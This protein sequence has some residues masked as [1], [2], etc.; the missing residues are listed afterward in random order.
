[1][2]RLRVAALLLLAPALL[3][4]QRAPSSHEATLDAFI[5]KGMQDWKIP[6][7]SVAVVKGDSV[8]YLKGFGVR[9]LGG[10]ERV[11]TGTLFGMM[12]T[13]K[14]MTALALAM[15]VDSGKVAWNDP[16]TKHLPWFQ[17]SDPHVTRELRVRD[18]LTHNAGL[19][20]A[21]LLWDRGDFSTREVL[22]R[23]RGLPMAYSLRSSFIYNNVMYQAAGEVVAA[24]S[25]MPWAEFVATRIMAPIGMSRS[26][27]T[28]SA[29]RSSGDANVSAAHWEFDD[30]IRAIDEQPVDVVPAAGAAWSSA[31]D[32]AKWVRFWLDSGRVNGKRLVS[33]A[34]FRE[35]LRPH[36]FVPASEFYPTAQVTRPHWVTYGLGWFEQDYRG[37]FVAM[38][39][40]SI[41]GRTAIFGLM[42]D[43]RLG[44]YVFGNLDHAEF[45]HALM[46]RVF[47]LYT[48]APARDWSAEF[49]TLYGDLKARA[50]AAVKEREG[51]R[52]ANTSPSVPLAQYAA[53]YRH[54]VWGDVQVTLMDGALSM[55]I[56]RLPANRGRL[57]HWHHDTFRG[58]L[59]DGRGGWT[60]VTF[61][62]G[63]SGTV[64]ALRVEDSS[65]LEFTRVE[66]PAPSSNSAFASPIEFQS[67]EA[68]YGA[69]L[70]WVRTDCARQQAPEASPR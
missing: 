62:L 61:R 28:L 52:V 32:V 2:R 66:A 8:L 6:G 19:G 20:N 65:D 56:G 21:D 67:G 13:T 25:G 57:E 55:A 36:A 10:A 7:L 33:E 15:L 22:E 58:R 1:M 38:H 68:L 49:L 47:D 43:E 5:T 45:R 54:P 50:A 16:V 63:A 70:R 17:L 53:T 35:L 18:L 60:Y 27:P 40:G 30:G 26:H 9:R 4:A 44:V 29:V 11:D 39:T 59:G 41:A 34:N 69:V 48:G 31:A 37:K 24:A 64:A 42:P 14:A 51:K 12:S 46:W 23:V 3:S